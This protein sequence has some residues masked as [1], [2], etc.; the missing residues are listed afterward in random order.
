MD[1]LSDA[2]GELV[3]SLNVA[4]HG[5]VDGVDGVF[6]DVVVDVESVGRD[7]VIDVI[8]GDGGQE[9]GGVL[10]PREGVVHARDDPVVGFFDFVEEGDEAV[11][12]CGEGERGDGVE[13]DGC[14]GDTLGEGFHCGRIACGG[15]EERGG[16][17]VCTPGEEGVDDVG[18]NFFE[19]VV[20]C[21]GSGDVAVGCEGEG[22]TFSDVVVVEE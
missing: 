7:A 11:D 18:E 2:V 8:R 21:A 14:S 5:F 17:G 9:C 1:G 10:C 13:G 6:V 22:F 4:G 20:F 3:Y 12:T 15:G 19:R 16:E